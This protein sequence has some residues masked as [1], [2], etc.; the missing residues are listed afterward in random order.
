MSWALE[1]LSPPQ[2]HTAH[3]SLSHFCECVLPAFFISASNR[4]DKWQMQIRRSRDR[5]KRVCEC[6]C[7]CMSR[8]AR[9]K[10]P[11]CIFSTK[12]VDEMEMGKQ[13]WWWRH[14]GPVEKR[15][16]TRIRQAGRNDGLIS[17]IVCVA[18]F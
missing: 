15:Q 12:W 10:S 7:M 18:H 8:E 2:H 5:H 9:K 13:W 6:V 14:K 3:F 11:H 1:R 17:S 16:L 4:H